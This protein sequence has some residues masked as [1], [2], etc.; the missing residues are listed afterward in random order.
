MDKFP[1]DE[2][3]APPTRTAEL[4]DELIQLAW[5]LEGASIVPTPVLIDTSLVV[6][7]AIA[8]AEKLIEANDYI[9]GVDRLH[10]AFQGHLKHICRKAE[11][12]FGE[13]TNATSLFKLLRQQHPAFQSIDTRAQEIKKVVNS[14]ASI[15]DALNPIRNNASVAHPN[16]QL[17]DK[18]E[19]KLVV[20]AIKTLLHYVD[21]KIPTESTINEDANESTFDEFPF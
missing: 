13:D 3:S 20:N 1:L 2:E 12:E 6:A 19:A 7:R 16:D 15:V 21:D 9:S 8:D 17:L 5:Q 4:R 11:I 18:A 14:L 10:T